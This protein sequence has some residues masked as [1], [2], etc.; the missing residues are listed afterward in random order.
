[1][2]KVQYT[3]LEIFL[4]L[5]VGALPTSVDVSLLSVFILR[6]SKL[7]LHA[8]TSC[9]TFCRKL[10][11]ESGCLAKDPTGLASTL[12]TCIM[13]PV[14]REHNEFS[15]WIPVLKTLIEPYACREA[16]SLN[17]VHIRIQ[18]FENYPVATGNHIPFHCPVSFAVAQYRC[19][20][21]ITLA[22]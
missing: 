18:H 10:H 5:S 13:S 19:T 1:M 7:K 9:P 12:L 17:E 11:F 14:P 8:H 16:A 6:F 4:V 22:Q 3:C 21:D 15:F 2:L 20:S